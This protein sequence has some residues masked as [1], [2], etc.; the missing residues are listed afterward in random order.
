ME[1]K[2]RIIM[3]KRRRIVRIMRKSKKD[4]RETKG[5]KSDNRRNKKNERE[6]IKFVR[7][8]GGLEDKE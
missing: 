4:G 6:R 5:K 2:E 7:R 3:K 1:E 8:E